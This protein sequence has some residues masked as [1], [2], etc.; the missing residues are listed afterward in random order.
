M[1][2]TTIYKL[3]KRQPNMK[4]SIF[5]ALSLGVCLGVFAQSPKYAAAMEKNLQLFDSSKTVEDYARLANTFERIG[6]AEKSQWSP[7]YYAGLALCSGGWLPDLKDKDAN[8]D[9]ILAL[10]SKAESLAPDDNAKSE[11][12]AIRNMANTQQMMVNPA[13]RWATA[14]K[15]AGDALQKGLKLN[16]NNPRLYYLQGMSLFGTPPQFGGGKDKAKPM[17]EKAV[18]L[19]RSEKPAQF[20]P[21]W[22]QKQA[23]EMLAQ[24]E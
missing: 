8:A 17:F 15:E 21:H 10:A 19:Y 9:R 5:L 13:V 12:Q 4:K 18:A 3:N 11:I 24:C 22:G 7:Y 16:A 1:L 14:G 23:E 6:D 20:Y 2:S